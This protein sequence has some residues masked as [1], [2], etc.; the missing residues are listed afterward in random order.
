MTVGSCRATD[1][2]VVLRLDQALRLAGSPLASVVGAHDRPPDV[3]SATLGDA[4]Y[5]RAGVLGSSAAEDGRRRR[6]AGRPWTCMGRTTR[7]TFATWLE[8]AGV[9]VR[10][11]DELMG[12]RAA[13]A[14]GGE[15]HGSAIGVVY[16]HLTPE[17]QALQAGT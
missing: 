1:L 11:I 15:A 5:R 10:V 14:G 3:Y 17:M 12:H 16:R 4:A 9:P 8:G 7:H 6:P 2:I 13:R